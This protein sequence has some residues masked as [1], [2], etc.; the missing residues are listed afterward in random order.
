MLKGLVGCAGSER[1][2][3]HVHADAV[4]LLS[5]PSVNCPAL[6]GREDL[7]TVR[8]ECLDTFEKRVA[9][10]AEDLCR[11]HGQP[12][13]GRADAQGATD[14]IDQ[15]GGAGSHAALEQGGVGGSQVGEPGRLV[16]GHVVR[17]LTSAY[18]GAV[19][20]WQRPP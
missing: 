4:R 18:C 9:T 13:Q 1:V 15:Q 14:A 10:R 16:M 12:D 11:A 6:S 2:G 5:R 17:Q 20:Y 3:E 8:G 19:M 7:D